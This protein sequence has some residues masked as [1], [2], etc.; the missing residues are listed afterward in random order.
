[1]HETDEHPPRDQVGLRGR[2]SVEQPDG[3]DLSRGRR[4]VMARDRVISQVPQE[5]EVAE[6]GGDV[7][8]GPHPQVAGG[9]AR[10]NGAGQERL[11]ANRLAGGHDS[12]RAAGRAEHTGVVTLDV[13]A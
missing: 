9:D 3:R 4:R 12:Q 8:E 7:L 1:V 2:D 5:I 10:K 6:S 13:T 11:A